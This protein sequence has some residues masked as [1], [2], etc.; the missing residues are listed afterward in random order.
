MLVKDASNAPIPNASVT[1]TVSAG[2]FNSGTP[3]VALTDA[4]GVA[5]AAPWTTPGTG[6]TAVMTASVGGS[7]PNATFTVNLLAAQLAQTTCMYDGWSSRCWGNGTRG[8]LGNGGNASSTTPVPVTVG[9]T[10]PQSDRAHRVGR[11][12][13][14]TR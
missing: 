3:Y 10:S 4:N 9:A 2:T 13:L 12:F 6:A 7:V 14:R 8:Q 1:F 11:S 5:T